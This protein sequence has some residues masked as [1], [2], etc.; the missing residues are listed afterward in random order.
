MTGGYH[1]PNTPVLQTIEGNKIVDASTIKQHQSAPSTDTSE[2]CL[3]IV[4]ITPSQPARSEGTH[5]FP[6]D[7]YLPAMG[8]GGDVKSQ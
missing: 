7:H 4:Q 1:G 6:K 3:G 5:S 8:G 2:N